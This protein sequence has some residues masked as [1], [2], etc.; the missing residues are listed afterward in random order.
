MFSN[1]TVGLIAGIG[2]A[3]WVYSKII[4]SSGGNSRSALIVAVSA[5][6]GTIVLLTT[7]LSIIFK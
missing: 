5:G 2:V 4:R 1:L 3:A 7:I 6:V